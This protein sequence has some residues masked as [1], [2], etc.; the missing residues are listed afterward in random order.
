MGLSRTGACIDIY[1]VSIAQYGIPLLLIQTT[2][3]VL[4]FIL[5]IHIFNSL[6]LEAPPIAEM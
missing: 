1:D 5:I 4:V 6:I 2:E 3:M